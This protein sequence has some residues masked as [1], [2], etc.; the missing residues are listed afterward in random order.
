MR[1]TVRSTDCAIIAR[2]RR[3]ATLCAGPERVGPGVPGPRRLAVGLARAGCRTVVAE[4]GQ[5]AGG[6]R[7]A[8]DRPAVALAAGGRAVTERRR[9]DRVARVVGRGLGAVVRGVRR[10]LEEVRRVV[11]AVRLDELLGVLLDHA[12]G[13]GPVALL[14]G[15]GERRRRVVP[16]PQPALPDVGAVEVPPVVGRPEDHVELRPARRHRRQRPPLDVLVLVEVLADEAGRVARPLQRH[17]EGPLGVAVALERGITA[18]RHRV[19]LPRRVGAHAGLVGVL[20]G[21]DAGAGDAAQRV[22]DVGLGVRRPGAAHGPDRAHRLDEVH[23]EVVHQHHHDVGPLRPLGRREVGALEG[24]LE[25]PGGGGGDR[26]VPPVEE[27]PLAVPVAA[28]HAV[29][30]EV[31][32]TAPSMRAAVRRRRTSSKGLPRPW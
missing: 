18:E 5:V 30:A 21:E 15:R 20:P 2:L 25:P 1:R 12:A 13:V 17:V 22:D 29:S 6:Q 11:V 10:D 26:Q 3:S 31:A 14:H 7:R 4:A 24:C 23:R 16:H 32:R 27:P 9:E 28:P 8:G 19:E